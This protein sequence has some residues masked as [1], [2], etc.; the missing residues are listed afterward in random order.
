M[1]AHKH[2]QVM[3]KPMYTYKIQCT[4]MYKTEYE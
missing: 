3:Q 2:A 4:C 1:G